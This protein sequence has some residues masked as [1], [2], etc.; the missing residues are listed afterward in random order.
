MS[1]DKT[2]QDLF[3][4]LAQ[5]K[6][7]IEE[8]KASIDK[9]WVTNSTFRL[10]GAA[11]PINLIAATVEQVGEA[12]VHLMMQTQ[13]RAAVSTRLGLTDLKVQGYTEA[14]WFNDFEKRIA[15][16]TV[17]DEEKALATLEARLNSVLSPDERRRI[18]VELLAK[19]L[20]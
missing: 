8:L 3:T 19:E 4:K 6:A 20:G 12:A 15:A 2:I 14:E 1:I 5:R 9:K 11:A 17:K 16:I 18:E 10:I 7:K 13:A